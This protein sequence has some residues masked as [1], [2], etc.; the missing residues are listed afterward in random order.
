MSDISVSPLCDTP[1]NNFLLKIVLEKRNRFAGAKC[2]G[3]AQGNNLSILIG[4][5]DVV[6]G[7]FAG[8]AYPARFGLQ[9][10][11]G[12]GAGHV[13][14]VYIQGH[15]DGSI[16]LSRGF[17]GF[18]DQGKYGPPVGPRINVV[19]FFRLIHHLHQGISILQLAEKE[20]MKTSTDPIRGEELFEADEI[21]T[22]HS[23]LKILPIKRFE[24][25]Q[26]EAPGPVTAK[27]MAAIGKVLDFSDTRWTH[28][29]QKLA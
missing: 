12:F 29:F 15:R 28:W 23:G 17:N 21:F 4:D 22:C 9:S 26:L 1:I 11:A 2:Q 10:Q 8:P 6:A 5:L 14:D 24:D 20:N 25:R 7:C 13:G 16:G 27:L 18:V 3:L 19:H